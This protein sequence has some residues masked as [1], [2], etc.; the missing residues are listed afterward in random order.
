MTVAFPPWPLLS[1]FLLA[2][3]VLAAS[4][5]PGV[6]YIVAR[7]L[8]QGRRVGLVSVA[9]VALGN[10]GNALAAALGLAAIFAVSPLAFLMLKYAGAVYL[11]HLG[12]KLLRRPRQGALQPVAEPAA[13]VF[14]AGLFVALLNPKTTLFFTAFLPQFLEP[15]ADPWGQ[16]LALGGLFVALAALTDSAYALAA[17]WVAPRLRHGP[18]VGWGRGLGGGV[19]IGLGAFA[20]LS[21]SLESFQAPVGPLP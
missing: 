15:G 13:R 5:G 9:G 20:A 12:V 1:A 2:S 8:A 6:M 17:G 16:S 14:R 21:G 19:C 7:S 11:I 10:L 3:L 18:V 4:P